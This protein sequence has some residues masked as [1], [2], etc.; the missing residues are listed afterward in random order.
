LR[1]SELAKEETKEKNNDLEEELLSN[2]WMMDNTKACTKCGVSI[3]KNEGCNHMTCKSCKHEF[4][5]V[6]LTDWREHTQ[7]TAGTNFYYACNRLQD[8]AAQRRASTASNAREAAT[9]KAKE[10]S[11]FY[12]YFRRFRNHENSR[13]L[14]ANLHIAIASRIAEMT[15]VSGLSAS[16][17]NFISICLHELLTNRTVL[18]N[19]YAYGYFLPL[20]D[21]KTMFETEQENL[22]KWTERLSDLVGRQLITSTRNEII[23]ITLLAATARRVLCESISR[24][25]DPEK[26][27]KLYSGDEARLGLGEDLKDR[28]GSI[29]DADTCSDGA[30]ESKS[31]NRR[32]SKGGGIIMES[33][34]SAAG[35]NS[36]RDFSRPTLST[37]VSL[38]APSRTLHELYD[39]VSQA[40]LRPALS[41]ADVPPS[42]PELKMSWA[43]PACTL[44]NYGSTSICGACGHDLAVTSPPEAPGLLSVPLPK[45]RSN[46]NWTCEVCSFEN[47]VHSTR[48][49]ICSTA[50]S[51]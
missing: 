1:I 21:I 2:L 50:K 44:Q 33:K 12:H 19:S 20:G 46:N 13:K 3:Q 18:R 25:F 48:C 24:G 17:F 16:S 47:A 7:S 41:K 40:A 31:M 38:R 15:R 26:S 51:S 45:D 22:E 9:Q 11:R 35:A 32:E 10:I 8:E 39:I 36:G 37:S 27:F 28:K 23:E 43:C 49:S 14:E 5:W 34:G 42:R 30:S 6:C 29:N 4:C